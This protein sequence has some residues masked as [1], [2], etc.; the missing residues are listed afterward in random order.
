MAATIRQPKS[1]ARFVDMEML[2]KPQTMLAYARPMVIGAEAGETKGLAGSR[3]A[4]M[5]IP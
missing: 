3:Q 5:I 2:A 1:L 4:Q